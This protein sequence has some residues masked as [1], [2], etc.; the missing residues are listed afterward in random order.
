MSSQSTLFHS[1]SISPFRVWLHN[2]TVV[3]DEYIKVF[4]VDNLLEQDK[5]FDY[6]NARVK[7]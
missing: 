2:K 3:A 7:V 1:L 6:T 4:V 5:E